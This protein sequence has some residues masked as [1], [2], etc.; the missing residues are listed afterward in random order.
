MIQDYRSNTKDDRSLLD[1]ATKELEKERAELER[2]LI[3]LY[4]QKPFIQEDLQD[5]SRS[6]EDAYKEDL[7]DS[8]RRASEEGQRTIKKPKPPARDKFKKLCFEYLDA[9]KQTSPVAPIQTK[10]NARSNHEFSS[11]KS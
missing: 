1:A 5:S 3:L 8:W 2:E 10:R 6:L 4:K 7:D 9:T 11:V